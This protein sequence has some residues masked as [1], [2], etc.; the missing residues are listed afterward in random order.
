M[1][2]CYCNTTEFNRFQSVI[3]SRINVF[4]V[5]LHILTDSHQIWS[6]YFV[7]TYSMLDWFQSIVVDWFPS[8]VVIRNLCLNYI[9]IIFNAINLGFHRRCVCCAPLWLVVPCVSHFCADNGVLRARGYVSRLPPARPRSSSRFASAVADLLERLPSP[10]RPCT[11]RQSIAPAC[12]VVHAFLFMA[13]CV[14]CFRD[15]RR[16]AP[17]SCS[18]R[19]AARFPC[20]VCFPFPHVD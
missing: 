9:K 12:R 3:V 10:G 18:A 15:A 14:A 13:A 16:P 4:F 20:R 17:V 2:Q 8:V 6:L 19:L 5:V 7:L 1:L 11:W